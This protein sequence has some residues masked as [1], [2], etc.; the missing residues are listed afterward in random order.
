M[1]QE[2]SNCPSAD[3]TFL[4]STFPNT[5]SLPA[6]PQDMTHS[7][8]KYQVSII[9]FLLF[10]TS[11]A[12]VFN[13]PVQ[14]VFISTDKKIKVLS[15][16]NTTLV[17]STLIGID[18]TKS[19]YI[20]RANKPL[21]V[22][23]QIDSTQKTVTLKP[24]SSFAYWYNICSNYGIGMLIDK[25]NPKRYGYSNRNYLKLQDTTIKILRF[26]PTNKGTI[27]LSLSLPFTTIFDIQAINKEY[28]S[29]GVFGLDAGLDYF[30][31]DNSYL[32][33]NVGTAT[34][35]FGEYVGTGYIETA[36]T[37]F[38]SLRK[39]NIVGS[40]D[41]GYGI[42]LSQLKWSKQTIGDTTKINASVKNI[43]LGLSLSAQYRIG[44]YL[45]LGILYQPDLLN[46]SFKPSFNYQ[47]YIS[48]NLIWK[49]PIRRTTD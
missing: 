26:A 35:R 46:T 20:P 36:S 32:S 12:T 49:L 24:K 44:N 5:H 1:E 2:L 33:I 7:K 28:K 19:Y 8:I 13:S 39:N 45:R 3:G 42:N 23:L 25:D 15:V 43:G 14:K 27:N 17:D 29:S 34:D 41:L 47:H 21:I 18:R 40:F 31:K 10:F 16:D 30:Y 22:R 6:M 37:I 4:S 9:G 48:L 38:A 11:C